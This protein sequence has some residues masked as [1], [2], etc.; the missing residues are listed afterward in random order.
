MCNHLYVSLLK[1]IFV[2]V[3]MLIS[4]YKISMVLLLY[5]EE[6]RFVM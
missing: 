4:S 6:T 3:K 2:N 5:F 1:S